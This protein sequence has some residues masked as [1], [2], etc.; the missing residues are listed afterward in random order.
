[1]RRARM[2]QGDGSVAEAGGSGC[3]RVDRGGSWVYPSWLLRAATRE[4]N[5]ADFRD[6]VVGFR[7][8]KTLP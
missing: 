6:V 1:M 5:P 4:R 7:V 8:A 2:A 3:L